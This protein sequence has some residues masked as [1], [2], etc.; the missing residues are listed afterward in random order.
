LCL[1]NIKENTLYTLPDAESHRP[2][3]INYT[4]VLHT[5]QSTLLKLITQ[6]TAIPKRIWTYNESSDSTF[7]TRISDFPALTA[8]MPA[9]LL[10][11]NQSGLWVYLTYRHPALKT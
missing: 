11:G 3:L 4:P 5:V 9:K 1:T 7:W 6:N 2:P 8:V 10:L